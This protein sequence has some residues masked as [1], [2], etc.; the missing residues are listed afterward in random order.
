MK[1]SVWWMI[2]IAVLCTGVGYTIGSIASTNESAG[3]LKEPPLSAE[4]TTNQR[5]L[6]RGGNAGEE[7]L[8]SLL[9]GRSLHE[10][11][12]EELADLVKKLCDPGNEKNALVTA[13]RNY[14]LQLLI[15]KLSIDQLKAVAEMQDGDPMVSGRFGKPLRLLVSAMA[16]KDWH[17]AMEWAG[18]QPSSSH[19]EVIVLSSL[20]STDRWMAAEIFQGKVISG[21]FAMS[22]FWFAGSSISNEIA[23]E[24]ASAFFGFLER[25]PASMQT[26][27][28]SFSVMGVPEQDRQS[29]LDE[30]WKRVENK[31]LQEWSMSNVVG[32]MYSVD[33]EMTSEWVR[34]MDDGPQKSKVAMQ[35]AS[36]LR[37]LGNEADAR[38]WM[39]EAFEQ[40]RGEEKAFFQESLQEMGYNDPKGLVILSEMLP[41]EMEITAEDLKNYSSNSLGSGSLAS[42]ASVLKSS[43]ERTKLI[44]DVLG[45]Y[46]QK[47]SWLRRQTNETDLKILEGQLKSLNLSIEQSEQVQVALGQAKESV[48]NR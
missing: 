23:K 41:K 25:L 2:G 38:E 15:G 29:V 30:V 16:E 3:K 6:E 11:S 43:D 34:Q 31:S 37:R 5:R 22:N 20:A 1:Y 46:E 14:E 18:S 24:G 33:P 42:L 10:W 17:D 32:N 8:A 7:L 27:M 13:R 35:L 19:L 40:R 26:Q 28:L 4:R 9:G 47:D 44:L 12:T 45:R 21:E 39:Q 48:R 36:S